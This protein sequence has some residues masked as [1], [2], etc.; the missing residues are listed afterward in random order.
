M[1]DFA[2]LASRIRTSLMDVERSVTRSLALSK[3]AHTSGDD[4][5]WDGVALNLHG[6][7]TGIEHILEDIA[8]TL[9]TSLPSGSGWHADLLTQMSGK[10]EGVRPAVISRNTRNSLDEF[11]GLRHVI[12]NVYAFNLRSARLDELIT[13]LPDCFEAVRSELLEFAKFLESI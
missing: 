7:Y 13:E 11:R 8:R 4:G 1:S 12:R 10:I 5:Y 3:K 9:E 2:A 6:F